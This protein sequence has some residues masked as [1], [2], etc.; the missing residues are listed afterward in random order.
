MYQEI[1]AEELSAWQG[2]GARLIDVR[3]RWEYEAGHIPGTENVP[4]DALEHLSPN[5][6]AIVFVCASGNRSGYAA[7]F[8]AQQ[9]A[10][11]VANLMGGVAAWAR[12][13]REVR[14]GRG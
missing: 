5:G 7:Q 14:R 2:R 13:G 9:G 12:Q 11:D 6:E 3:E 4:F 1:T 10:T 8:F